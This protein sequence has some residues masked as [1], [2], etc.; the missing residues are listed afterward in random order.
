M[1]KLLLLVCS[2]LMCVVG[3]AQ[4]PSVSGKVSGRIN[5]NNG[6]VPEN[7]TVFL[8]RAKDS[9]IAKTILPGKDG[10]FEFVGVKQG[11][12]LVSVTMVGFTRHYSAKFAID[13]NT[14]AVN[15]PAITLATD[16]KS[17]GA[18]TVEA[19]KPFIE[20]KL[21]KLVVNVESSIVG[22]G[23]SVLEVLERSPGV[24]VNQETS[25]NLQGKQGVI[26]MIDG[27]PTPLSGADLISYL[28]SIPAANIAT[29]EIITQPSAR[30]DAAGNAGIINIRFKKD[31][32]QG[33]NGT[34]TLSVGQGVYNK[35]AASTNLNY[36]KKKW[37]LFGNYGH[38]EPTQ[39]T[40]FYINRKFYDANRELISV[41]DQTSFIKTPNK[42]DN[43]R[44]GADFYASKRTVVGVLFNT[45]WFGFDRDGKTNSLI[46]HPDGKLDYV[47]RT[48]IELREKRFNGFGNF[49]FKHTFDSTGRELTADIDYG[50]FKAKTIQDVGNANY[51]QNEAL[52]GADKL[53][54][55]QRGIITVKSFKADYINPVRNGGKF[56]AGIK[57]SFVQSDN[58]VKFFDV[59]S[60]SPVLD[61][62]QSNHFIYDENVNAA[63]AS[64]AKE[65]KKA[66]I[67]I[68]ARVEHTS[69]KGVQLATGDRFKRSY[70]NFFPSFVVNRKFS[71]KHQL[72]FSYAKRIDRPSYRQLNPFRI[73]VDPYTYVVG[74]PSLK[75]VFTHSYEVTHTFKNKY[76]TTLSYSKTR[77]V[78]TDV[79]VQDDVSKI[80]YQTPANLQNFEI[81]NL[82]V[83]APYNIKKWMNGNM[84]A[85]F[86]WNKYESPLQGG[87]LVNDF[88]SWDVRFQN[89]FVI[90]KKG[91]SA[92]LSGFYQ[93]RN[94]WGLFIIRSLAQV[95]T[96]VQKVSKDK[97]STFRLALSDIFYTNHIAVLVNYQNMDFFTDRTWDS[98]VL[99]LSFTHRF[100]K[101]TVTR[102]RQRTTG[103]EDEKRRAG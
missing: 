36:R 51:D 31:Q 35:P 34:L 55:D 67:Q 73:F 22:A 84:S 44:F 80:S 57:T 42:V 11:N 12:Y 26:V 102:A 9:G 77:D 93:A 79:F 19:R 33:F 10:A 71:K 16:G 60:G 97:N 8:L 45:N 91:W 94:A 65:Y 18:V 85:N 5:T 14:T 96:G 17:L 64:F 1:Y 76:M 13:Q 63:Y 4:S 86:Y 72:S 70:V 25:I 3:V 49:N 24:V 48:L 7:A 74:E 87:N 29:I 23:N 27:K 43:A 58:D 46:T 2:L 90:G 98:R 62:S 15:L 32:R 82:R 21:D 78:I 59:T 89:N 92:E 101:N 37:N 56:E 52:I 61:R 30:Y 6:Q 103:V 28:K 38:S 53:Q 50:R 68:G 83:Y 54:T 41:F 75:A 20:R 100:G 47:T 99:T 66:D 95:S 81:W 69:T 40:N 39:L 88:S